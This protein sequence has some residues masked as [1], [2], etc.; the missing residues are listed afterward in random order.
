MLFP[1][2][3]GV[4]DRHSYDDEKADTRWPPSLTRSSTPRAT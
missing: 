3:E 2:V 4:Y 1:G